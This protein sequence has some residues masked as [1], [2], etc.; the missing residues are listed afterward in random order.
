MTDLAPHEAGVGLE[1]L[2]KYCTDHPRAENAVGIFEGDWSSV[3]PESAGVDTGGFAGLFDDPR[4]DWMVETLGGVVGR[5]VLELGPLEGGHTYALEHKHDA[6]QIVAIEANERA[7]LKCLIGKEILQTERARF[8]LGDFNR[9]MADSGERFDVVVACGVLYHMENPAEHI[10]LLCNTADA[11][12]VWTHY[13][14]RRLIDA[15]GPH[16]SRKFTAETTVD[17]EGYQHVLYRQDYL[18]ALGWGGFCGAG[19]EYANWLCLDDIHNLFDRH[20]FA[21]TDTGF[22][23]PNHPHGPALAFVA[24]RR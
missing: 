12:F 20:G 5:R 11:V 1:I 17:Y 19:R 16:V 10:K 8:L 4:I 9:Y 22:E 15:A 7:Y 6:A 24:R 14:D 13:F 23:D 2:D 18:D 21:I 3:L